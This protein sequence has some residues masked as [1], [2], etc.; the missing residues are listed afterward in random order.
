MRNNNDSD[1]N[2]C[3]TVIIPDTDNKTDEWLAKVTCSKKN[4]DDAKTKTHYIIV[5][6]ISSLLMASK[7]VAK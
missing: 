7:A 2:I 5:N 1:T 3:K 6:S 4:E